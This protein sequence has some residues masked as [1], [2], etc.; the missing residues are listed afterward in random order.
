[1]DIS[2]VYG[3]DE[4]AEKNGK[5]FPFGDDGTEF[6]IAHIRRNG[7]AYQKLVDARMR[8]YRHALQT[9]TMDDDLKTKIVRDVFAEKG[10][11][12]W[13]NITENGVEVPYSVE[14][15]KRLLT[16]YPELCESLMS[17]ATNFSNFRAQEA[18]EDA[19]NFESA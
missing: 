7:S 18:E 17:L 2:K 1:M 5:W 14:N 6:L 12:G 9:E 15:A 10:V 19:K 8:P 4:N 3:T 16:S 13:K 11:L